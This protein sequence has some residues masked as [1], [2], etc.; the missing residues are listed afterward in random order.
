MSEEK[1]LYLTESDPTE[2]QE[3]LAALEM[4]LDTVEWKVVSA[5]ADQE[6]SRDGLR[7]ITELSRIYYLKNP[8]VGR[9]VNVKKHYIWGQGWTIRAQQPE[10]QEVID[11]FLYDNKNDDVLGSHEARTQLEVELETDGNIFFC[12]FPDAVTGEV[13]IRTICFD[14][15]D[16]IL[17]NPDDR[18]EPWFYRRTWEQVT[19]D[20]ESGTQT[21]VTKIAYYPDWRYTPTNQAPKIGEYPI[22]W[23]KPIYH[24]KIGGFSN[25]KF[26]ISEIYAAIDWAKAYKLN[27]EDWAS[28][29]RAYR[30]FAYQ[31]TAPTNKAV[32][33]IKSRLNTSVPGS[34]TTPAQPPPI[35]GS[36]FIGT[37]DFALKAVSHN[38]ATVSADD[39]RRLMLMVAAVQGLPETFYG[40]A[41][42]GTLATAESLDRPTELMMVDRQT[43]WRDITLNIVAFV[44][45]WAVK[46]PQGALR[47]LGRVDTKIRNGQRDETV[48]WNEGVNDDVSVSFPPLVQKNIPAMVGA[49]VQAATL[50]QAGTLAGTLDLPA[51][52]RI[53]LTTL[54]VA[55]ADE[56][57]ERL[58]PDG[59]VPG[60]TTER[61]AAEAMMVEA[62]K[63][64]R[65]ALVSLREGKG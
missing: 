36:T 31:L 23:D 58:F 12:F 6:F 57:V 11:A 64:L 59:E 1:T 8:L 50:G 22:Y 40:D 25:W 42:V 51:L 9:G 53:L 14:E 27:L 55:D 61:P 44:E 29:I 10:I 18:K 2:L 41:S 38:G 3:R 54:G 30:K 7:N 28:I 45:L 33:Q 47:S 4:F 39:G 49:V 37:N 34:E 13:A 52:S 5:Q 60:A 43:L 26:G 24:V 56:I 19:L 16:D 48:I 35:T 21:T 65:S 46:A 15:I 62:V 32:T 20:Y 63:E 17:Y